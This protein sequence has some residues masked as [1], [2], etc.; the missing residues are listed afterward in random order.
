MK[1]ILTYA[2]ILN[3]YD[4]AKRLK[5]LP[6]LSL[7]H[8][9][10]T[11]AD[12]DFLLEFRASVPELNLSIFE[13]LNQGMAMCLESIFK[14]REIVLEFYTFSALIGQPGPYFVTPSV[15]CKVRPQAEV[16]K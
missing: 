11:C 13:S 7:H 4:R 3:E 8:F 14:G 2:N 10:F 5:V 16:D 15:T 1:L 9:L 12:T 6:E